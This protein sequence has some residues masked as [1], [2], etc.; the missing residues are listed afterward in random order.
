MR[1]DAKS[2]LLQGTATQSDRNIFA[3]PVPELA[4]ALHVPQGQGVKM[5]KAAYGLVSAPREW[6][7]E[8]NRVATEDCKLRQFKSDP[9][10]WVMDGIGPDAEPRGFITSHATS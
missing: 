5:L 9:C 3:I 2:A 4:D 10:M 6:F 8:V 1:A 7:L